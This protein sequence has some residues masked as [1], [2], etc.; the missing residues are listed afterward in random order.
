MRVTSAFALAAVIVVP[1]IAAPQAGYAQTCQRTVSI[2]PE[3]SAGEGTG[4]AT[5]K[6]YSGG[7]AAAGEVG[8][9]TWGGTAQPGADFQ[10]QTGRLRWAAGDTEVKKIIVAILRDTEREDDLEDF[11]VRLVDPGRDI[12][13]VDP[14]ARGRSLDDEAAVP[15]W[16]IDDVLCPNLLP[17]QRCG[18]AAEIMPWKP[19]CIVTELHLSA[20]Q[21]APVTFRWSTIDGT[22][23]AGI[24]YVAVVAQTQTVAAGATAAQLE[25][26]LLPR[27]AATSDRWFYLRLSAVSVG[28]VVDSLATFTIRGS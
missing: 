2:A 7:C 13:I 28:G 17:N 18:C 20:L 6:V 10:P 8:Y 15:L 11:T 5:F 21:P 4:T 25:V 24:D 23:R 26:Q 22:A 12:S 19:M 9:E 16:S 27:S 1:A 14:I 3:V